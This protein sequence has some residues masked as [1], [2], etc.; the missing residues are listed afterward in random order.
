MLKVT[1][2]QMKV[3]PKPSK[4]KVSAMPVG[5][6][7][8]VKRGAEADARARE[9]LATSAERRAAAIANLHE[10]N[11][12]RYAAT[13]A[14]RDAAKEA[15]RRKPK[16]LWDNHEEVAIIQKSSRLRFQLCSCTRDGYRYVTIR[17]WY[18]LNNGAWKPSKNG[19]TIP[20][21][22]PINRTTK[23]D[24]NNKPTFIHPM[25]ELLPALIQAFEIARDMELADP[26]NEVW[27]HY[28]DI[29]ED[30]ENEN[31]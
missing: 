25:Q 27:L 6:A 10:V 4:A 24:P 21:V 29:M 18:M 20:L 12:A 11:R 13:K 2:S 1:A 31:N 7:A 26:D 30:N 14:E 5:H 28:D 9:Y 17:E 3:S 15:A 16:L 8:L 23:P 19:I 22:M